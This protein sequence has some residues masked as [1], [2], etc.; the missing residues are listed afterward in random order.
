MKV[1]EDGVPR[2]QRDGVRVVEVPITPDFSIRTLPALLRAGAA[3]LPAAAATQPQARGTHLP[4]V[5]PPPLP[6]WQ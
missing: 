6:R 4:A 3:A 5:W 1:G 2:R